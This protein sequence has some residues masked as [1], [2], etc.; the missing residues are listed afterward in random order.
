MIDYTESYATVCQPIQHLELSLQKLMSLI[1]EDIANP[2]RFLCLTGLVADKSSKLRRQRI[3]SNQLAVNDSD[4]APTS[5]VPKSNCTLPTSL[6]VRLVGLFY[7][8]NTT[9]FFLD[10][11]SSDN[12]GETWE[13]L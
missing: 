11:C 8:S 10:A 2:H 4:M 6:A 9:N 1:I 7:A 12:D 13:G 3:Q 5:F